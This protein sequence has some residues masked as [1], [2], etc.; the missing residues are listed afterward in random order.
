MKLPQTKGATMGIVPLRTVSP[1]LQNHLLARCFSPNL[2][3]IHKSF[4]LMQ[5]FYNMANA[6]MQQFFFLLNFD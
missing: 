4:S 3:S 1:W 5:W 2:K 6:L